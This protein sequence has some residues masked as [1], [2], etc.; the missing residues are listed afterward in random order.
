MK[1]DEIIFREKIFDF[2]KK[3]YK[4]QPEY[5]WQTSPDCAVFRQNGNTKWYGIIMYVKRESLGLLGEGYVDI[6][7]VKL[8]PVMVDS[9]RGQGGFLPAYHMNKKNWLTILLDGSVKE[10]IIYD[11]ISQSHKLTA[12]L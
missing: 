6:L 8:E 5:L 3:E 7:N 4:T 2:V 12:K 10:E 1:Q 11:L 9:L